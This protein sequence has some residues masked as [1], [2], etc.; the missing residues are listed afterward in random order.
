MT[1]FGD[2]GLDTNQLALREMVKSLARGVY[3]PL[4]LEWDKA[5][6]P[7]PHDERERLANLGLLGICLP[8]EFGGSGR[9]LID[10]LLVIEELAKECLPSAFCVFEANTG[11]A[12]VVAL[13]GTDD[14]KRRLLP[15]VI[16]GKSTIAVAISEPD[17]GSAATD[18]RMTGTLVGDALMLDGVKRWCS[19]AGHAEQYL[20]Y[21]RLQSVPGSDGIGA[22]IVD[23]DSEGLTF[24]PREELMGFRS[25]P[26]ADMMFDSVKVAAQDVV[27]PAGGFRKLF[28]AFSIERLGNAT[29]SLAIA[30]AGL[31]RSSEYVR[32]RQQFGRSLVTFQAVQL[33]IADMV[34][35][36]RAARLL[37]R[38]AAEQA[39]D[40]VPSA[41]KASVAKSYANETAKYVSDLAM[42]LHGGYGYAQETGLER[43]H[44]DAHGWALAGGTPTM[45]KM[46]IAS[47]YMG[48]R[49]SQRS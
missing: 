2:D 34:S 44:R 38:D 19:G 41:L 14:Q 36:V 24:G 43:L 7:F 48:L 20:V 9:P 32:T 49:F 4:A 10:A 22:V 27:V 35:R 23:R 42:Q 13:F 8:E 29:M 47:E 45:Q 26:S 15:P 18:L 1:G 30:Q 28:S 46:R 11:P 40:G 21:A 3:R 12:R 16:R 25:I 5:G 37:I 6:T 17:A 33:H 31:D 39:G